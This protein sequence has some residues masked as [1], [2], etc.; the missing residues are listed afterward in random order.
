MLLGK[1][2]ITETLVDNLLSWRHGGFS[3]HGAA[4]VEDRQGAILDFSAAQAI[5]KSLKLP[6]QKPEPLAHAPPERF[7]LVAESACACGFQFSPPGS[8]GQVR[9]FDGAKRLAIDLE[10]FRQGVHAG[11]GDQDGSRSQPLA[12]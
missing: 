4:R 2:P 9:L 6:A 7:E 3:A 8:L 12:S 5:R 11:S 10:P 1:E